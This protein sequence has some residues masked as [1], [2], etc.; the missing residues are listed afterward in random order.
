MS[1]D[2]PARCRDCIFWHEGHAAIAT[3]TDLGDP[4]LGLDLGICQF[5]PPTIHVLNGA[6]YSLFPETHGDRRCWEFTPY[7]EEDG[8]DGG[9]RV[10]NVIPMRGAA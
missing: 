9:S 3:R 4:K 5:N 7:E 2:T 10:D 1:G 8:P 6:P